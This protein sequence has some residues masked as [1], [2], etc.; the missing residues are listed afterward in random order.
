MAPV[1][2]DR[3]L[4]KGSV[5]L[6]ADLRDGR[7]SFPRLSLARR[8]VQVGEPVVLGELTGQ[9]VP[10]AA[11]VAVAFDL[12]SYAGVPLRTESGRL[13]G[14]LSVFGR[15]RRAWTDEDVRDLGDLAAAVTGQIEL[16]RRRRQARRLLETAPTAVAVF[17]GVSRLL[18][19]NP[20][21]AL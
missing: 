20:Q 1:I 9:P 17:G 12:R 14:S 5:G 21:A 2:D 3:Q 13:V 6:P 16:R 7:T 18:E 11:A 10:D 8:P 15:E 19:L 4:F